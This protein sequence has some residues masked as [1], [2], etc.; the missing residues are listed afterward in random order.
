L[1]GDRATIATTFL[2]NALGA[3]VPNSFATLDACDCTGHMA[4]RGIKDAVYIAGLF[5]PLVGNVADMSP[6]VVATPTM[7]AENGQNHN[8]ADAVTGS[9]YLSHVSAYLCR[10]ICDTANEL[11]V[12]C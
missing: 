8:V 11:L 9:Q 6:R 2:I 3:P 5:I 10:D 4:E 7:S 1:Y 12:S